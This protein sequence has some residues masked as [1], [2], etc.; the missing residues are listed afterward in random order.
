M[1]SETVQPGR[2]LTGQEWRQGPTWEGSSLKREDTQS[3]DV[4][5]L[6]DLQQAG[7]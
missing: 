2:D 1:W 4:T 3:N 7:M 5:R 6:C